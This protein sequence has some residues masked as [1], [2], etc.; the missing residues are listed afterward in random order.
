MTIDTQKLAADVNI[1]L[2]AVARGVS[3]DDDYGR[4]TSAEVINLIPLS[5]DIIRQQ[6]EVIRELVCRMNSV[7]LAIGNWLPDKPDFVQHTQIYISETIALAAPLLD[8]EKE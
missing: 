5:A 7:K 6:G 2:E 1:Y 8:I 3:N 4:L